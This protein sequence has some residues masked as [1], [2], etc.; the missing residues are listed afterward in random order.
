[1]PSLNF[2]SLEGIIYDNR[3]FYKYQKS[4]RTIFFM[5]IKVMNDNPAAAGKNPSGLA[6]PLHCSGDIIAEVGDWFH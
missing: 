4:I 2:P 6:S 5:H 3:G 1:M